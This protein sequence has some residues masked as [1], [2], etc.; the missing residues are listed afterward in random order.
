[1]SA[2]PWQSNGEE[3]GLPPAIEAMMRAD[4]YP[5]R[6]ATVEFVQTHMSWVFLAGE[7][8]FKVKKAVRFPFVD[9][10]TLALRYRLCRE[11]VRLNR[12]L[13]PDVYLGVFPIVRSG[14]A[15][16]LGDEARRF[17]PTVVEYAVKMR[18]LPA[19][20]MLDR[21]VSRGEVGSERIRSI[22]RKL[23]DFHAQASTAKS[24]TY[25]SA[26]ATWRAI[27]GS[28]SETQR[29][30]GFTASDADFA[31][32]DG[33]C[34]AF[35][36]A[37]WELLNDRVRQ[38]RVREG[39][40]DLRC[41]QICI[42]DGGG[43]EI[44]DC[45]EFSERLRYCDVASDVG[46]LAMDLDRLDT[47]H[48]ADEL[49][50]TYADMTSDE[51]FVTLVPFYKCYRATV[52]AK[53]E[54]L[55]GFEAEVPEAER[56]R[57]RELARAYFALARRYAERGK[58]AVI[59]VCGLAGTGKSTLAR[60]LRTRI[61]FDVLNSDR[62][63]KR[64]AGVPETAHPETG[65]GEGI[66]DP[67]FTRRTY[68]GM[69]NEAKNRVRE[70][71]G[72]ILDATFKTAADRSKVLALG[73]QMG[74]PVLFVEC[75]ASDAEIMRRLRHRERNSRVSD[76]N[77]SVFERQRAEFA[78]IDELAPQNHC[79]ADTRQDTEII[80]SDI[81]RALGRLSSHAGTMHRES[82]Q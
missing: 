53:V 68:D 46:F 5:H 79:V 8:V 58:P 49:V 63:R 62:V 51:T 4:F 57:A 29:F 3:S 74:V 42:L 48:L 22:A 73:A 13:A 7:Y 61:G 47:A 32:V 70:G 17:D 36:A 60:T 71:R 30:L 76:A 23:A 64:L 15:F 31:E 54:S 77:I 39:H 16:G 41:E 56:E 6:P 69:L 25:G 14:S 21:M 9:C 50:E 37:H 20:R 28:L 40:G 67:D 38:K 12:R 19:E 11:E 45:L 65:Y 75:R 66:Y 78:A 34:S 35:I 81:E 2:E 72:V 43:I 44:F 33:Y 18:R 59:V 10:S 24:W 27:V 55:K 26:V 1:M 52:R 82:L 80:F